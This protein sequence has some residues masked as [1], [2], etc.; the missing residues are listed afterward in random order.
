MEDEMNTGTPSNN[1]L[2]QNI[3]ILL[4]IGLSIVYAIIVSAVIVPCL[5]STLCGFI[6]IELVSV[7]CVIGQFIGTGYYVK[8]HKYAYG[9]NY[10]WYQVIN[11]SIYG[12]QNVLR[13]LLVVAL[14]NLLAMPIVIILALIYGFIYIKK[15]FKF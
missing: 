15:I 10:E 8:K 3:F 1:N 11:S 6:P 5:G 7:C 9:N 2:N 12:I 14:I 4:C 13:V